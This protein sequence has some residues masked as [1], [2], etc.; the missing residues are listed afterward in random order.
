M[1]A[2]ETTVT[3]TAAWQERVDSQLERLS[4]QAARQDAQLERLNTHVEWLS[5]QAERQDTKLER[6]G[7][8]VERLSKH[9]AQLDKRL[10]RVET[11]LPHLATKADVSNAINALTWRLA[12][13]VT[14][15]LAA[16]A[17]FLKLTGG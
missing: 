16:L 11:T 5:T 2:V 3:P 17:A 10:V 15:G 9:M 6:L 14:A 4:T 12:A 8:Y 13:I 1:A 7:T